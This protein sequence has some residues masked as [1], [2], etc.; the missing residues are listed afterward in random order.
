[1]KEYAAII[2]ATFTPTTDAAY[3]HMCHAYHR[4]I[5]SLLKAGFI[6]HDTSILSRTPTA[7]RHAKAIKE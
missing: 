3:E 2:H 1:M 6:L 7:A 4:A 5:E